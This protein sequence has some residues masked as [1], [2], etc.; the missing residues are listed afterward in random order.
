MTNP[1]RILIVDDNPQDRGL[2]AR[3][4]RKDY[5]DAELLEAIDQ[6]QLAERLASGRFDFVV[7]DFQ[8]MW[9][10]GLRVLN[11]V[12]QKWPNCPVIMF[13]ATGSEEVAVEAMKNG[14]DDYVIKDAKHLVR[15]SSAI[16]AALQH[17][18]TEQRASRLSLELD[19][20]LSQ[21]K[22]GVYRR[23]DD[24]TLGEVNNGFLQFCGPVSESSC[25]SLFT[26]IE[27]GSSVR[28]QAAISL[29][30]TG[31]FECEAKLARRDEQTA[32]VSI[33]ETLLRHEG[34]STIVGLIEDTTLRKASEESLQQSQAALAHMARLSTMG[35]IVAGIAHEIAQPLN[36]IANFSAACR[37]VLAKVQDDCLDD[38]RQ[39]TQTINEQSLRA[40]EIIR[41]LQRFTEKR[42]PR[43]DKC[44][45]S[46]L[47]QGLVDLVAFDLRERSVRL[48]LDVAQIA[49]TVD[50]DRVQ[51]QQVLVN[52]VR[53]ACEAMASVER[54]TRVV[55]LTVREREGWVEFAVS[56]TGPG[57]DAEG[58]HT[59]FQPFVTSKPDGM[60][61]GLA[62]CST[63][64][65]AHGGRIIARNS[66]QGAV[67]S[68]E[69]P[70]DHERSS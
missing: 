37:P 26:L 68:F 45:I 65:K 22:V 25:T 49:A 39:W 23:S 69:L 14:L 62:I 13:T 50:A 64:I 44:S 9:S 40:A 2:V 8:L 31:R 27:R 60:G 35:E 58:E 24:G 63:I 28:E 5:P 41:G 1:L 51:I 59:I 54:D 70:A 20:L 48:D 57:I 4:L 46:T 10:D 7:T 17:A 36:A 21:L 29:R 34:T 30:D 32:W 33:S 66:E 43:C 11:A 16:R 42:G 6:S 15:L 38:V 18:E 19:T 55:T 3:Q 52:L 53:N 56:D 61:M 67:F 47:L 12:K